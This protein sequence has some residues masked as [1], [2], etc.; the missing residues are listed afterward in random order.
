MY[1]PKCGS[2]QLS[3]A[4][5]FCSRCGLPLDEVTRLVATDGRAL[6]PDIEG[7]PALKLYR[8]VIKRPGAKL[9]FFSIILIPFMLLCSIAADSPI[10]LMLDFG[11]FLLGLIEIA[12][13]HLFRAE[14]SAPVHGAN[15][16]VTADPRHLPPAAEVPSTW[17]TTKS[18]AEMVAP[19][20]VTES[21]TR[22]LDPE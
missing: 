10:P 13:H 4:V 2:E 19:P 12:Y 1:C 8:R 21:T 18:T 17:P 7:S 20:S 22:L 11:I 5:R 6:V 14:E 15:I 3:D 16:A 9:I